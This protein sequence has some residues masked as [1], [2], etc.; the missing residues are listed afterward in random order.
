VGFPDGPMLAGWGNTPFAAAKS[1]YCLD[2]LARA[3]PFSR[4][5]PQ[6]RPGCDWPLGLNRQPAGACTGNSPFDLILYANS[7]SKS[8][9]FCAASSSAVRVARTRHP[10]PPRIGLAKQRASKSIFLFSATV[11]S[12]RRSRRR[13]VRP[14][15]WLKRWGNAHVGS[16]VSQH[17]P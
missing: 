16:L 5:G 6:T 15:T 10:E 2:L 1:P 7:S 12:V 8:R 13:R 3:R 11:S 9:R 17:V 14:L 4:C